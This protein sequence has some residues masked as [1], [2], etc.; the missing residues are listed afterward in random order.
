M[1]AYFKRSVENYKATMPVV[2]YLRD[3]SLEPRH[4]EEI[5]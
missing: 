4:W 2:T 3:Q 5:F 1:A